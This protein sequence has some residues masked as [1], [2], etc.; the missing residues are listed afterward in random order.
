[1]CWQASE[2]NMAGPSR[3]VVGREGGVRLLFVIINITII[4]ATTN[5]VTMYNKIRR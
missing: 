2:E 3:V 1:M 5:A 4:E